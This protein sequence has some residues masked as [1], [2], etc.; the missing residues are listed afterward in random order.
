MRN[1]VSLFFDILFP[2]T[3]EA[4]LV[5]GL[6]ESNMHDL[7]QLRSAHDI[8]ALAHF[9]DARVRALIHE[10][11]FHGNERAQ[12]LLGF[13]FTHYIESSEFAL[14]YIIIPVPLSKTRER[15]RGYNQVSEVLRTVVSGGGTV[16]E[17]ILT[18]TKETLPQTSLR[19]EA[20]EQNIANAFTVVAP[21]RVHGRDILLVDDVIT[22]G[23]TMRAAKA[24]LLPHYPTSVTCL[25]FAH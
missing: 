18:R 8:L 13:L 2:P 10:A 19:K 14:T 1:Y 11:K 20:R 12:K 3:E 23:A 16:D 22:T 21:E 9:S 25:A 24:A 4:M 6:R 15:E 7:Y 5:R 17:R